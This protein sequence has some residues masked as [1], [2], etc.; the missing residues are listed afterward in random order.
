M[1]LV[2]ENIKVQGRKME[3]GEKVDYADGVEMSHKGAS[4][5]H[6]ANGFSKSLR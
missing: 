3:T 2:S 5:R 6:K 1:W 4:V